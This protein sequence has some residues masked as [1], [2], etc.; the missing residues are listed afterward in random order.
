MCTLVLCHGGKIDSSVGALL[1]LSDLQKSS[2]PS[3]IGGNYA[4][5]Q[6]LVRPTTYKEPERV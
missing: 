1:D 5:G 6:P 4:S 3:V 2:L